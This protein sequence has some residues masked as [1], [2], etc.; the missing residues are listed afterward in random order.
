VGIGSVIGAHI[1]LV[2]EFL[3]SPPPTRSTD[4]IEQLVDEFLDPLGFDL[5]P[6]GRVRGAVRVS[7]GICRSA[8][9]RWAGHALGDPSP[10][11]AAVDGFG[12]PGRSR[13]LAGLT[14]ATPTLPDGRWLGGALGEQMAAAEKFL[15]G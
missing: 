9:S 12:L 15:A 3:R 7:L 14:A 4:W 2:A 11:G 13:G 8:C 5:C 10:L 1:E 6:R